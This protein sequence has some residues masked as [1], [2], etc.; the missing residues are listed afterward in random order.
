MLQVTGLEAVQHVLSFAVK[1]FADAQ[2][3]TRLRK[4]SEYGA[5]DHDELWESECSR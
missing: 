4:T 1:A 2:R 3:R 5:D